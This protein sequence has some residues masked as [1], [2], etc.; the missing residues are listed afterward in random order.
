M[1]SVPDPRF[2]GTVCAYMGHMRR[3]F[4]WLKPLDTAR[5]G[6]MAWEIAGY[7]SSGMCIA[8]RCQYIH[9][10]NAAGPADETLNM[11]ME[12][13]MRETGGSCALGHQWSVVLRN[14]IDDKMGIPLSKGELT[15]EKLTTPVEDLAPLCVIIKNT[16]STLIDDDA[17]LD[18]RNEVHRYHDRPSAV[19][20]VEVKEQDVDMADA[21]DDTW[22][23]TG[24]L[25]VSDVMDY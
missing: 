4:P 23:T 25:S 6:D 1:A 21:R 17:Q 3:M 15:L 7:H 12:R 10:C 22:H 2:M 13:H 24:D 20:V 8:V 16:T 11:Y 19:T 9:P 5:R 18:P 14:T